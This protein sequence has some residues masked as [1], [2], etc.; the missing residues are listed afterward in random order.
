MRRFKFRLEVLLKFRK[1]QKEQAQIKLAEAADK[2]CV[3]K[4]R[5]DEL[6]GKLSNTVTYLRDSQSDLLSVDILKAYSYYFDKLNEDIK[7]RTESVKAAE[8]QCQECLEALQIAANNLNIIEKLRDKRIEQ[9]KNELLR[10][11]QQ[12]LDEIGMQI[13]ARENR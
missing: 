10:E 11:E 1:M 4:K 12:C 2:L 6:K 5:L 7:S 8:K 13:Y 3:E 9:Y